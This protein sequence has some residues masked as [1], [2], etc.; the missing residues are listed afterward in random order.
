MIYKLHVK[1]KLQKYTSLMYFK[2]KTFK[3]DY[4]SFEIEKKKSQFTIYIE[5]CPAAPPGGTWYFHNRKMLP[6]ENSATIRIQLFF[7]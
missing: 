3:S 6:R 5:I 1:Y 7:T 2:P 4:Y